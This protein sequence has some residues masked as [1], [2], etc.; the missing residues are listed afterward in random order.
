MYAEG[1]ARGVRPCRRSAP[2]PRHPGSGM[3][4]N[5]HVLVPCWIRTGM[6]GK[7]EGLRC[8]RC[9]RR[10][11]SKAVPSQHPCL[12]TPEAEGGST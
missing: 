5:G 2:R 3:R 9:G 6:T 10:F 7:R 12:A 8:E 1:S 11:M 4:L